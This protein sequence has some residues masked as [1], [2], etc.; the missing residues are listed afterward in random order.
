MTAIRSA[1][2]ALR[3]GSPKRDLQLW[4]SAGQLQNDV[5]RDIA[6]RLQAGEAGHAIAR[7]IGIPQATLWHTMSRIQKLLAIKPTAVIWA[8]QRD[9]I[10]RR[11]DQGEDVE[12][13]AEA[14]GLTASGVRQ[15]LLKMVG[16]ETL[17]P[18]PLSEAESLEVD[19]RLRAGES[20]TSIARLIGCSKEAVE[21]RRT[22]KVIADLAAARPPCQCGKPAGHSGMCRMHGPLLDDLRRRIKKGEL[23]AAAACDWR[24]LRP[25]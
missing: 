7:T 5:V 17:P 23:V 14:M 20:M 1:D 16:R 9:E 18:L 13:I 25:C 6:R 21:K 10:A 19:R 11:H 8:E 3:N 4:T 12:Q 15:R 2:T 24:E 22:P